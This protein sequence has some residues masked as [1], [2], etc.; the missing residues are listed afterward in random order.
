VVISHAA[1]TFCIQV[2]MFETA[3]AIQSQRNHLYSSG[4][5]VPAGATESACVN[6]YSK[7]FHVRGRLGIRLG[8]G[9]RKR[10]FEG[11]ERLA[12]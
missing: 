2:P 11:Q 8:F 1:P 5:Q 7:V 3:L 6:P 10:C 12:Q 9:D 4:D